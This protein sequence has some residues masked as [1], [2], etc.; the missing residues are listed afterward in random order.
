MQFVGKL[1]GVLWSNKKTAPVGFRGVHWRKLEMERMMDLY[2]EKSWTASA[3]CDALLPREPKP[4]SIASKVALVHE[5]N[6]GLESLRAAIQK[7]P[8]SGAAAALELT[9]PLR[10]A[11]VAFQNLC[12]R[13]GINIT[14]EA[15]EDATAL[16][17]G[18]AACCMNP[19]NSSPGTLPGDARS[20]RAALLAAGVDVTDRA[21]D[22]LMGLLAVLGNRLINGVT[23]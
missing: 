11:G 8:A 23:R 20:G 15:A 18:L 3:H 19:K 10:G 7:R 14:L 16:I 1:Y 22:D 4:R 9:M 2:D 13:L 6:Q 17:G 21:V 12:E 5:V